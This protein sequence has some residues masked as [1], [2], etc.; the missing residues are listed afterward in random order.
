MLNDVSAY[1]GQLGLSASDKLLVAVSGGVDSMTLLHLLH[2]V[3]PHLEVAHCN[4]GLRGKE[5]EADTALVREWCAAHH[6]ALHVAHFDTEKLMAEA[7]TSLQMVARDLR[8][9]YFNTLMDDHGL[10][11]TALAHHADDRLESLILN[12]LRGTGY[13][14]FQGMP[15][16]RDRFIRP[17]LHIRKADLL[18]HAR[19]NGVPYRD[20]ASNA[21]PDYDR[22][23]VRLHLLPMLHQLMPDAEQKLLTLAHR[24]EQELTAG[25]TAH[26]HRDSCH[27]PGGK[28]RTH[29]DRKQLAHH[30]FPFTVLKELLG[31]WG[32]STDQ[33][34]EMILHPEQRTGRMDSATHTAFIEPERIVVLPTE[35]LHAPPQLAIYTLQRDAETALQ[36]PKHIIQVDAS[37]VDMAKL[38]LRKW[39]HGDRF[40][41]LWD[42]RLETGERPSHRLQ[43][44]RLGERTHMAVGSGREHRLGNRPSDGRPLPHHRPHI[45]AGEDCGGKLLV[46]TTKHG[47]S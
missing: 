33:V 45:A 35:A 21:K 27:L 34:W 26:R 23:R 46:R 7:G 1:L 14:G 32:F 18:H 11:C 38:T 36:T 12:L 13:R 8:Y 30:P 15:R 2:Q 43:M 17:L 31:P 3:H 5:S 9:A 42:E 47:Y 25:A 10:A 24:T 28:G 40:R 16:Q 41:P 19:S 20:D 29:I 22:N 4:Y 44:H 39:R 37:T 6:I